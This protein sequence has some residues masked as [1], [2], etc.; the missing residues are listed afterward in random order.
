MHDTN[1][2]YRRICILV[3]QE[4]MDKLHD[5]TMSLIWGRPFSLEEDVRLQKEWS[6]QK[7]QKPM[8][9]EALRDLEE[10]LKV[11]GLRPAPAYADEPQEDRSGPKGGGGRRVLTGMKAPV[12]KKRGR[13]E[14]AGTKREAPDADEA[15]RQKR[16]RQDENDPA[17]D[18]FDLF[19][20]WAAAAEEA[21]ATL[22]EYTSPRHH[23]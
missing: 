8:T 6:E 15:E 17:A 18:D 10:M 5:E 7:E 12:P 9:P 4:R 13:S 20:E 16:A 3:F 19:A 22:A 23:P 2:V 11:R 1:H 21:D 14:G